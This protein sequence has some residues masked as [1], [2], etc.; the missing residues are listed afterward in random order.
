MQWVIMLEINFLYIPSLVLL[1][2]EFQPNPFEG[3]VN[4]LYQIHT[5]II[6]IQTVFNI[7][8]RYSLLKYDCLLKY[9]IKK[10][11]NWLLMYE[12]EY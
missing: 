8:F 5:V 6:N 9:G 2:C 10:G 12:K 1:Y 11:K 7:Q 4:T 3:V